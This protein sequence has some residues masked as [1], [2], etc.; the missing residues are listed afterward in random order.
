MEILV[1]HN[2]GLHASGLIEARVT[3]CTW[4]IC[5]TTNLYKE[6]DGTLPDSV[7]TPRTRFV[8]GRCTRQKLEVKISKTGIN[9]FILYPSLNLLHMDN[10][11]FQSIHAAKQP[12][13]LGRGK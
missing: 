12:K 13:H 7:L 8:I 4:L 10:E 5:E 2:T 9:T 6:A 3:C 1:W 11:H